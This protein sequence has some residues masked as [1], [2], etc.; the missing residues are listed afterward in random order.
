MEVIS[1]ICEYGGLCIPSRLNW[2]AVAKR[3]GTYVNN[4]PIHAV[5]SLCNYI[6]NGTRLKRALIKSQLWKSW[7]KQKET[8]KHDTFNVC[9][10]IM[11]LLPTYRNC[12]GDY[13]EFKKVVNARDLWHGI[14]NVGGDI[15]ND[16]A[17][18]L[19]CAIA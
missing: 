3:A 2:I 15:S 9:V 13:E 18:T 14:D 11:R 1:A 19:K 5:F 12:N 17:G 7:Q 8:T 16:Q 4:M 6:E 10:K